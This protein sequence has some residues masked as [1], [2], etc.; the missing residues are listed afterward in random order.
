[1]SEGGT[2]RT[3]PAGR[4]WTPPPQAARS[5]RTA[6]LRRWPGNDL[7]AKLDRIE[8]M[9]TTMADR[10]YAF[11]QFGPMSIRPVHGSSWAPRR[12]LARLRVTYRCTQGIRYFHGCYALG[13]DPT[14]SGA[15]PGTTK[16]PA[17]R[18]P[19]SS[20]SVPPA[21]TATGCPESSNPILP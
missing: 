17:T 15:S 8:H 9:I 14:S 5:C 18:S 1:M 16:A 6:V 20:P 4:A 13:T 7:D 3:A 12:K 19:R 11:D 21:R 2:T 10:C